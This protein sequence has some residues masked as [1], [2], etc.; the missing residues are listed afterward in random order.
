MSPEV[1]SPRELN[2]A[3][4]HADRSRVVSAENLKRLHTINGIFP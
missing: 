1:L 3:L 2:R 4:P